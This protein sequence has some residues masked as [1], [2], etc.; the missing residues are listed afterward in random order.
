MKTLSLILIGLG[1]CIAT[2]MWAKQISEP[3]KQVQVKA[4]SY[5]TS[6]KEYERDCGKGSIELM[7]IG[8]QR[9]HRQDCAEKL[10]ELEMLRNML[11]PVPG[12][13]APALPKIGLP[14]INIPEM[15]FEKCLREARERGDL[16]PMCN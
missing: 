10:Q 3:Q 11:H 8:W 9:Q 2:P 12:E 4:Q 1:L 6:L 13:P 5:E 14:K 7:E 15:G 16:F